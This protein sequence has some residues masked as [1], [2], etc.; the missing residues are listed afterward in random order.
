MM[1]NIVL[2][3]A[4]RGGDKILDTGAEAVVED[5]DGDG[6]D[7]QED[8]NDQDAAI[9]PAA[10]EICDGLDNNCDGNIDEEVLLLFYADADED[11]YGNPDTSIEACDLPEG[12]V[13]DNTDCDDLR[14]DVYAGAEE[15]TD[16]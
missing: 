9:F 1:M 7:A 15:T 6:F 2:L 13:E 14:A 11:G 8:C 4:C 16:S 3:L 12:F 5:F 10:E